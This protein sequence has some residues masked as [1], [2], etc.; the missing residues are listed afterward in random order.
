ME[1]IRKQARI[2]RRRLTIERFLGYLP[3]ALFAALAC[4]LVGLAFPKFMFLGI[5]PGLWFGSWLGSVS[6]C[7]ILI[8]F[9][10]TFIGRPSLADA[11]AEIDRRCGLKERLS[12][13]LVLTEEDR[14]TELGGALVEDANRRAEKLDVREYFNLGFSR[15]LFL[16]IIPA[17]LVAALWF[18]P[19]RQAPEQVSQQPDQTN[20]TQ[21]KN[22]TKNL[23]Q[24][25]KKKREAAEKEGLAAAAEMFKQLEGE[26]SKLQKDTKID[27]KQMLTK[28]NDIKDQL[29][30]RKKELG[31]A[32]ALRKNLQNLQKFEAGPADKLLDA[33]KDGDFDKAEEALEKLL[34][35]IQSGEMSAQDTEKL[36]KQL[37]QMQQAISEA[38]Q[39]QQQAKQA[40]QE[41]IRQAESAG[42]TQKAAQLQ[43]KLDQMAGMEA[44]MAQLQQ[45]SDMLS[46]ASE[47]MRQGDM[48]TASE[49]LQEMMSQMQQMNQSDS[50]LQDLDQL[51]DSLAQS[52]SQMT[53]KNCNGMG[54]PECMGSSMQQ[55]SPGQGMGD[56]QGQGERPEEENE[57]DFY[58]SQVREMM[59][60]GE[61]LDGGK[62]GGA[63]RKGDTQIEV[64]QAVLASMSEEPEPLDQTPLPKLQREHTRSYFNAVREGQ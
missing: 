40:L 46:K 64:Q 41:Q 59:R 62:V 13:A 53:C 31:S 18:A 23:L 5:E 36:Q 43:R 52:K 61:I 21:V 7:A 20:L 11:A 9:W 8:A 63:N 33:M 54:C 35:K 28:L 19:N 55:Q 38:A 48:Q 29:A 4:S 25:V 47:S 10:M 16:P 45:M 15:K 50:E 42:D 26:L 30:E 2:A 24:E 37:E 12:S 60:K 27:T 39:A 3:W 6:I 57:V 14:Q 58:D 34:E 22:S 17:L 51:M 32:D 56:G 1:Q 49:S 44:N